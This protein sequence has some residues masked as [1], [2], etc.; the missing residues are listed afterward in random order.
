[1]RKETKDKYSE[2]ESR[3]KEQTKKK[4]MYME[5]FRKEIGLFVWKRKRKIVK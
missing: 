2:L 1:M 4:I 3:C 5:E